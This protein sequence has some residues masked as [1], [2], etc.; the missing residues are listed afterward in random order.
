MYPP[1]QTSQPNARGKLL[2]GSSGINGLAWGRAAATEYDA[3]AT[4]AG[5]ESWRWSGL[6]PFMQKSENFSKTPTDPYPGISAAEAAKVQADLPH[7]DGFS[8]PIV[9]R[10][11]SS[12]LLELFT[13]ASVARR[14]S[15]RSTSIL[16]QISQ[17]R[18]TTWASRP[19]LS[20][21]VF[22]LFDI[23]VVN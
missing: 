11:F 5:D 18:S 14:R 12:V 4:I 20:L 22:A 2:G 9:V 19:T 21:Y 13:Q 15:T 3:W 7:I 1:S 16:S 23:V 10:R 17:S 8:G 6:L